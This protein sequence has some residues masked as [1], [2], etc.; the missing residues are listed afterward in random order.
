MISEKTAENGGL[1]WRSGAAHFGNSG[2]V[3]GR[4]WVEVEGL[5]LGEGSNAAPATKAPLR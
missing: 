4:Y 2:P 5:G 1:P 3:F